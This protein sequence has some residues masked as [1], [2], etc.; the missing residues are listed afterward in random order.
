MGDVYLF[1]Y[2]VSVGLNV[3]SQATNF[4]KTPSS[5]FRFIN[6]LSARKVKLTT[7]NVNRGVRESNKIGWPLKS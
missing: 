1:E 3:Y 7:T 5:Y 6:R 2:S 4:S